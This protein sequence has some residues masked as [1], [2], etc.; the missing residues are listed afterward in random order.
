MDAA[1]TAIPVPE[2]LLIDTVPYLFLTTT[3]SLGIAA[4]SEP[5]GSA[6]ASAPLTSVLATV[7]VLA[8][9]DAE[10]GNKDSDD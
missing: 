10:V 4:D 3:A 7:L 6:V 8:I 1:A 5:L 2:P 9:V